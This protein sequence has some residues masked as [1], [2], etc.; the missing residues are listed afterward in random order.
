LVLGIDV[1]IDWGFW[2][3]TDR[4]QA[5]RHF[6]DAGYSVEVI[7]FDIPEPERLKRNQK[8]NEGSDAN[9]FKIEQKDVAMFDGFFEPLELNE[10]DRLISE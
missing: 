1:Y 3:K 5:R 10:Y 4:I 2:T 8:R 7:Y 6:T 9:S